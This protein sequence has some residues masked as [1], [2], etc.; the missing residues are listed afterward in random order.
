[1]FVLLASR[2]CRGWRWWWRRWRPRKCSWRNL[3]H[4]FDT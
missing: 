3:S 4:Q 1:V 2:V